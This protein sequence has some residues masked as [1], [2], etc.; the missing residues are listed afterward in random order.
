MCIKLA[1]YKFTFLC[2]F[3]LIKNPSLLIALNLRTRVIFFLNGARI[4]SFMTY[5]LPLEGKMWFFL[6]LYL[7]TVIPSATSGLFIDPPSLDHYSMSPIQI[8]LCFN[9]YWLRT[10]TRCGIKFSSVHKFHLQYESCKNLIMLLFSM[11][12]CQLFCLH[13]RLMGIC[14]S[15]LEHTKQDQLIRNLNCTMYVH[16]WKCYLYARN[17]CKEMHIYS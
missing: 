8:L 12:I 5:I 6:S 2:I 14:S 1:Y 9:N 4:S 7:K 13:L 17:Q 16:Y 15:S 11:V 10:D 3:T